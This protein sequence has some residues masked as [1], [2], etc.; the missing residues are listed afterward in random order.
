MA[1]YT[2]WWQ[3]IVIITIVGFIVFVIFQ[4]YF[5]YVPMYRVEQQVFHTTDLLNDAATA[6][7]RL[8]A[9]IDATLTIIEPLI[10]P[11]VKFACTEFCPIVSPLCPTATFEYCQT[12]LNPTGTTGTAVISS[13]LNR[14]LVSSVVKGPTGPDGSGIGYYQRRS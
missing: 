14:S 6:A 12:I 8:E 5:V 4:A 13:L 1:D 3:Y 9:K 10:L 11:L 7:D 2:R